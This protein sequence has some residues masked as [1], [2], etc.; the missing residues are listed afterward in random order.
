M[1]VYSFDSPG[2]KP[3]IFVIN[4]VLVL[5]FALAWILLPSAAGG[6]Q[7]KV[8]M[9]IVALTLPL[10]VL[11]LAQLACVKIGIEDGQLMVGGGLYKEIVNLSEIDCSAARKVNLVEKPELP[12]IR[13]NGIGLPGFKLGWFQPYRG[14]KL[15]VLIAGSQA[16]LVP[17]SKPYDLLLSPANADRLLMDLRGTT[18]VPN[19]AR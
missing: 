9:I 4:L 5:P 6:F 7:W 14:K 2:L 8:P 3:I 19:A 17:T 13:T 15:F 16:V 18:H 1:S 12:G 11:L 10:A